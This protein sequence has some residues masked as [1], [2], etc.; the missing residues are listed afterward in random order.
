[1]GRVEVHPTRRALAVE[2]CHH[3][4]M[5]CEDRMVRVDEV[6]AAKP[7]RELPPRVM[8]EDWTET[9]PTAAPHEDP[10][11]YGDGVTYRPGVPL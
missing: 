9:K 2:V 11:V 6:P 4:V 3:Q 8:P 1:M 7:W 5:A 10:V